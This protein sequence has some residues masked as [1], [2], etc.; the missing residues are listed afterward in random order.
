M[1]YLP[2]KTEAILV[3]F[4]SSLEIL[5][6]HGKFFFAPDIYVNVIWDNTISSLSSHLNR[7]LG[8]SKNFQAS[9]GYNL[10]FM[11]LQISWSW[12]THAQI[13]VFLWGLGIRN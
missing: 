1:H 4:D 9:W 10:L 5:I 12:D 13:W 7:A 3:V 6:F 2:F 8:I 11:F